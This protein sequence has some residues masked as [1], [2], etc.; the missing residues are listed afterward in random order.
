[1]IFSGEGYQGEVQSNTL[2]S[3]ISTGMSLRRA[4]C[5]WHFLI[6]SFV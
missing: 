1:M 2:V 4:T 5:L 3:D 6:A